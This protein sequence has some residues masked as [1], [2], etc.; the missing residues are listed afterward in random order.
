MKSELDCVESNY[1]DE[2]DGIVI[3]G[4]FVC[5]QSDSEQRLMKCPRQSNK[6]QSV[7]IITSNNACSYKNV[8][9]NDVRIELWMA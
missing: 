5:L 8:K 1:L 3:F 6:L 7:A 4:C 9:L 2:A